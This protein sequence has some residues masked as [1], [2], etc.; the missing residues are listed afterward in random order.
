M[1]TVKKKTQAEIERDKERQIEKFKELSKRVEEKAEKVKKKKKD[2]GPSFKI[3]NKNI[4]RVQIGNQVITGEM[5]HVSVEFNENEFPLRLM[6]EQIGS[7]SFG[8]REVTINLTMR[9]LTSET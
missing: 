6:G 1:A 8:D 3:G 7:L 9:N 5:I 4:A 2:K